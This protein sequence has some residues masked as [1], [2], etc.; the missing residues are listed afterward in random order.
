MVEKLDSAALLVAKKNKH[1]MCVAVAQV[2]CFKSIDMFT[3]Y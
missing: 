2:E 1:E 3:Q